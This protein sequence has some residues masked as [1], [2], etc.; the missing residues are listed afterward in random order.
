MDEGEG[1]L[2]VVELRVES[3]AEIQEVD[4]SAET[5]DYADVAD[6]ELSALQ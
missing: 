6:R 1:L 2:A 5:L 3:L 4:V